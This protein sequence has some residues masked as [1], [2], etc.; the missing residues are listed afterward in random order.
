MEKAF[1]LDAKVPFFEWVHLKMC[2]LYLRKVEKKTL[3]IEKTF[4]AYISRGNY[5]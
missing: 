5:N 3:N 4:F 1:D 2:A